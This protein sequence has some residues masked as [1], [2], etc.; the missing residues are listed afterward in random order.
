MRKVIFTIDDI[1]YFKKKWS[2]LTEKQKDNLFRNQESFKAIYT[3]MGH[4]KQI[5][6]YKLTDFSGNKISID[7]LNGY[8]RGAILGD[9]ISYFEGGKYHS[10]SDEP[11]GVIKIEE[12]R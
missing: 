9:C 4:G 11:C 3:L 12:M 1:G 2:Y 10:D 6:K 5:D 8:Q 7:D